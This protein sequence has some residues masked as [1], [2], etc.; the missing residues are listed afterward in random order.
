MEELP[1]QALEMFT[2]DLSGNPYG[3]SL[4]HSEPWLTFCKGSRDDPSLLQ[5]EDVI[6]DSPLHVLGEGA[7]G[8]VCTG[9]MYGSPVALKMPTYADDARKKIAVNAIIRESYVLQKAQHPNVVLSHGI[10]E[11]CDT[12][13][14]CLVLEKISGLRM[15][16]LF[17]NF[18][19]ALKNRKG[20][21]DI[22]DDIAQ[23]LRHL[24]NLQPCIVHIDLKPANI[25]IEGWGNKPRAKLIDFGLSH[26]AGWPSVP[27]SG[28]VRWCA[29][30][31]LRAKVPTAPCPSMDMFSFSRILYFV[32][33][34]TLPFVAHD[35]DALQCLVASGCKPA[36]VWG[37]MDDYGEQCRAL[38]DMISQ[39][40]AKQRLRSDELMGPL[41]TM[42]S[43]TSGKC[44]LTQQLS[45]VKVHAPQ[46]DIAVWCNM[47]TPD[48]VMLSCTQ[49]FALMV[50][51]DPVNCKMIDWIADSKA[52]LLWSTISMGLAYRRKTC[53]PELITLRPPG[54]ELTIVLHMIPSSFANDTPPS[55]A[56][57][58]VLEYKVLHTTILSSQM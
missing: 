46:G 12:G 39:T 16:E 23:A 55:H 8:T 19:G 56:L 29:P 37:Q 1:N 51:T 15:R 30:E 49:K 42:R 48:F 3:G 2:K 28:T 44:S 25:M 33:T 24:H 47:E 14:W 36:L 4:P 45:D 31:V 6:L 53:I 35:L 21:H 13:T 17:H 38:S 41:L 10:F 18:P 57:F 9:T 50:Q 43:C 22:L 40:D 20:C 34:G 58:R 5:K 32:A 11:D 54:V 26:V 27:R 7:F 52:F